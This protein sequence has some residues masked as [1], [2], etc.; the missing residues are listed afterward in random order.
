M[1]H[2]TPSRVNPETACPE[3]FYAT[4]LWQCPQEVSHLG[5][6]QESSKLVEGVR[7]E[8]GAAESRFGPDP[9]STPGKCR[10][11]DTARRYFAC[12][13]SGWDGP[14]SRAEPQGDPRR[15]LHVGARPLSP[16]RRR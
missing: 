16:R 2:D 7:E 14:V 9:N 1:A 6:L 13:V 12:M 3:T 10:W 8:H 5:R 15:L 4:P 11:P